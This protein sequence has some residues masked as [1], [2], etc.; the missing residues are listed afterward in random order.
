MN[1]DDLLAY[2]FA[3][4]IFFNVFFALYLQFSVLKPDTKETKQEKIAPAPKTNS[5]NLSQ[6]PPFTLKTH[7]P[8]TINFS[9]NMLMT[10]FQIQEP[11]EYDYKTR[12][13]VFATRLKQI[14]MYQNGARKMYNEDF[15]KLYSP[16]DKVFAGVQDNAPWWG[17]KG[18]ACRGTTNTTLGLSDESRFINNPMLLVAIDTNWAWEV[19]NWVCDDIYPKPT[20]LHLVPALKKFTAY[21]NI[22]DFDRAI[23][24]HVVIDDSKKE[25][26]KYFYMLSGLN[27]RDFGFEYGYVPQ[28]K[29]IQFKHKNNIS[30]DTYQFRNYIH[31]A[32]S[33]KVEGGCNNGSPFQDQ[34]VFK[35]TQYPAEITVHLYKQQP[36]SKTKEPDAIFEL[37]IN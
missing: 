18:L 27:A 23:N 3:G 32:G 24:E 6:T 28:Y 25:E 13:E 35:I 7:T 8:N 17:L 11:E 22:S 2:I 34:L 1:K 37:I 29:N 4:I 16:S 15:I 12:D 9:P 20:M 36:E 26:M 33:C 30:T 19:R 14:Q 21:Y 10:S 5:K 31:R